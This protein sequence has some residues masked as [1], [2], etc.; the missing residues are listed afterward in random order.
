[1]QT[2]KC[3]PK[4]LTLDIGFDALVWQHTSAVDVDLITDCDIVSENSH[5]FQSGPSTNSGVPADNGAFDPGVILDSAV[6]KKHASLQSHTIANDAA[7]TNDHVGPNA[8][9]LSNFRGLVAH[10]VP[11]IDVGFRGRN[12]ALWA[13]LVQRRQI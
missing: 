6:F 7:R 13:A 3:T 12:K 10:D 8:T 11:A 5:I 9:I 2:A 4:K 1:M